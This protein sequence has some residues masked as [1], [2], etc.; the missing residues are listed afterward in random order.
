MKRDDMNDRLIK[1]D[2][3]SKMLKRYTDPMFLA[4]ETLH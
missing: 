2:F 4:L 1:F 3:L